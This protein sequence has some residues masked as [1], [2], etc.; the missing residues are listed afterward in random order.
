[1]KPSLAIIGGGVAGLTAAYLLQEKFQIF[2]FEKSG[3]IGGNA[4]TL[5]TPDGEEADIAACAFGKTSYKNLFKLFSKLNIETVSPFRLNPFHSFGLS[6]SFCNLENK[7]SLH[8]TPGIKGL[9]AQRFEILRPAHLNSLRQLIRGLRRAARLLEAG[10]LKGLSVAD[11]LE[12]IPQLTG[13]AKLIF[14]GD[15][16]LISSMHCEDVLDAPMEFFIEKLRTHADLFPPKA[17]FSFHFTRK[18]TKNYVEALSS[19]YKDRIRLNAAIKTVRRRDNQIQLVM[20]DGEPLFFDKVV[21]A[22]NADQALA[23]LEEPTMAERRLLG[24][25]R[26][27]EGTIVVHSDQARFPKRELMNGYTFLYKEKG[28]YIESSI[29]GSLWILPGVS[30]R[31]H[32]ISTQHPNFPIDKDRIVFEKVFR[33]PLFDFNS[34]STTRELPALNGINS[35]YYC[36]SHFGFGVHEDAVTSAI[37][38][39]EKLNVPF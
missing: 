29:S 30:D 38:V 20:E 25:W 39:A 27:T 8:L 21:F 9:L 33:T 31:C 12:K 35:S 4:Y 5:T 6:L 15:L 22:C 19:G 37:A 24:A 34:C 32:L 3:R 11:A 26:Y 7:K 2:L 23:L 17:I 28:R 36:G 10:D 14:I 1:V 13:E 18:R 16:C